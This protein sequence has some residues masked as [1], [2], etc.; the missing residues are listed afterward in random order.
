MKPLEF[1]D[2]FTN[3]INKTIVSGNL[4][5][6]EIQVSSGSCTLDDYY[7]FVDKGRM[8][9]SNDHDI[10]RSI[11]ASAFIV[12]LFMVELSFDIF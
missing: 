5:N 4:P 1:H 8:V 2:I 12:N 11:F 10:A 9:L 7:F 6:E 3:Q